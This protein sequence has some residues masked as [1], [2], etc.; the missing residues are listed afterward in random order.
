MASIYHYP[1]PYEL[2]RHG[3]RADAV[4]H[5]PVVQQVIRDLCDSSERLEQIGAMSSSSGLQYWVQDSVTGES[6]IVAECVWLLELVPQYMFRV[7]QEVRL[8]YEAL[9]TVELRL[10]AK[11]H[12][13]SSYIKYINDW[14]ASQAL[15][16]QGQTLQPFLQPP[17]TLQQLSSTQ[18]S[19]AIV[20]SRASLVAID[21]GGRSSGIRQQGTGVAQYE[22]PKSRKL[23]WLLITPRIPLPSR[24][25]VDSYC[26]FQSVG[27]WDHVD[28]RLIGPNI[29]VNL[30]EIVAVGHTAWS[31]HT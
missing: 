7:P 31:L 3:L 15:Q 20:L 8:A 24:A 29:E 30:V 5:T 16:A 18:P 13:L 21:R 14:Q 9:N 23:A 22:W 12:S 28:V 26:P 11:L 1:V 25:T 6:L 2:T 4:F 27:L 10:K 19:S 17:T